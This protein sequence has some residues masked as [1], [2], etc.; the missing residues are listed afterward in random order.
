MRKR[1]KFNSVKDIMDFVGIAR[2]CNGNVTIEYDHEY[3]RVIDGKSIML[4]F[5]LDLN[6]T[7]IVRYNKKVDRG[8]HE[9]ISRIADRNM[10]GQQV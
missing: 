8:L 1:I 10:K 7:L 9:Y 4:I 3:K 2:E 6:K 5:A